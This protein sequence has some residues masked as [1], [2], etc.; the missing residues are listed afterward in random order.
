MPA[1]RDRLCLFTSALC[2]LLLLYLLGLLAGCLPDADSVARTEE[3]ASHPY[4]PFAR[5][6][7]HPVAMDDAPPRMSLAPLGEKKE[8]TPE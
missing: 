8:I 6:P 3:E 2:S 1:R 7:R 4:P 5:L